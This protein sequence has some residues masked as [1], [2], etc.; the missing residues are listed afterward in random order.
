ML[1]GICLDAAEKLINEYNKVLNRLIKTLMNQDKKTV[2]KIRKA[3]GVKG[4]QKPYQY[5][6][7]SKMLKRKLKQR[8]K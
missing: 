7:S 1:Y 6:L 4:Y 8:G 2:K 5:R 3:L